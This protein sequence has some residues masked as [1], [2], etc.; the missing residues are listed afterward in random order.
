MQSIIKRP[1]FVKVINKTETDMT[2]KEYVLSKEAM[3]IN[4]WINQINAD[5]LSRFESE[6]L[7][8]ADYFNKIMVDSVINPT[9]QF[10]KAIN[11]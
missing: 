3:E 9:N 8:C 2:I 11:I 5:G 6:I 1:I 7:S 10:I 4:D